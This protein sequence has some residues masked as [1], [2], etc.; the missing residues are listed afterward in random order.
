MDFDNM[1]QSKSK[2]NQTY[3][4]NEEFGEYCLANKHTDWDVQE[5]EIFKL[6]IW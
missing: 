2:L 5:V 4:A 1:K 3:Q 6:K